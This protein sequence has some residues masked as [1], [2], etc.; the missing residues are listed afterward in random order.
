MEPGTAAAV[1][2]GTLEIVPLEHDVYACIGASGGSN[3]GF[4]VG[5]SGVL[6]IDT[7]LNPPMARVDQRPLHGG[8]R[9]SGDHPTGHGVRR[10]GDGN[11]VA[12]AIKLGQ[13]RRN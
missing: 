1:T 10:V 12:R 5:R 9:R 11:F 4:I 13:C 7:R 8:L 6:V 3:T 2:Q